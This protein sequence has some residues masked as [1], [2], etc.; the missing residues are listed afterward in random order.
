MVEQQDRWAEYL[1]SLMHVYNNSVHST[2]GYAPSYLIFRR[3]VRLLTDLLLGTA[4][5]E[6]G[7]PTTDWMSQHHQRLF[8]AYEKTAEH[9][10]AA[11]AKSKRLY[12]RTAQDAPLLPSERVLVQEHQHRGR[13]KL[14][15]RWEPRP[16]VVVG[17]PRPNRPVYTVRPEGT[18]GPDRVLH[19]NLLRPY[20]KVNNQTPEPPAAPQ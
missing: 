5:A 8:Y 11:T 2:T 17:C 20:P 9:L 3:H 1:P 16:Y 14:S 10:G 6:E 15:D 4:Q 12:D 19:R 13:G 18:S 7:Q